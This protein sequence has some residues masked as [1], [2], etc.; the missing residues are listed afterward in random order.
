M[1][2]CVAFQ[3]DR[4]CGSVK[5]KVLHLRRNNPM[6]QYM[7]GATLLESSLAEKNRRV[8]VDTRLDTSQQC[9]LAEKVNGWRGCT[10]GVLPAG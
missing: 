6:H 5:S 9:A 8:L 10:G 3:P 4:F 1:T 2:H 7:L